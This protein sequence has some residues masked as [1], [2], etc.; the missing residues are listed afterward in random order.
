MCVCVRVCARVCVRVCVCV[1]VQDGRT[2]LFAAACSGNVQLFEWL[3]QKYDFAPDKW[4]KVSAVSIL[5]MHRATSVLALSSCAH[6]VAKGSVSVNTQHVWDH[7]PACVYLF[8]C[9]CERAR[10]YIKM[11]LTQ[12]QWTLW[13]LH[14][15]LCDLGKA[16]SS[17]QCGCWT[18]SPSHGPASAWEVRL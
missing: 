18:R 16:V 2:L 7:M 12:M 9:M 5:H 15:C 1:Y 11:C 8:V 6:A 14:V 4:D 10:D 13:H 3:L 17:C